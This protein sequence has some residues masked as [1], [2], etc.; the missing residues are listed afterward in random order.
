MAQTSVVLPNP[1]QGIPADALTF[2]EEDTGN[3]RLHRAILDGDA[4][5][6]KALIAHDQK[7]EIINVKALENTPL[8]LALKCGLTGVALA[9]LQHPKVDVYAKDKRG[10]RALDIACILKS[11]E[12]IE[13][14]LAK[15]TKADIHCGVS[16]GYKKTHIQ[17]DPVLDKLGF[18]VPAKYVTPFQLYVSRFANYRGAGMVNEYADNELG[19]SVFSEYAND[20]CLHITGLFPVLDASSDLFIF[21]MRS[22]CVNWG[23]KKAT[24][25]TLEVNTDKQHQSDMKIGAGVLCAACDKKPLSIAIALMLF[26]S[27]FMEIAFELF[28]PQDYEEYVKKLVAMQ[29]SALNISQQPVVAS[30][31]ASALFAAAGG[32]DAAVPPLAA[33]SVAAAAVRQ[34]K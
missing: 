16:L 22:L 8:M 23:L 4:E 17:Y 25:F 28:F 13:L 2:R 18:R 6:A 15:Y 30:R 20:P 11:D 10:L 29:N 31:S 12:V 7:A 27:S 5:A 32:S 19:G 21:H 9:I 33:A 34:G 1:K 3:T 26:E 24:D 14:L